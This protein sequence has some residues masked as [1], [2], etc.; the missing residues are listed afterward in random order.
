MIANE[1]EGMLNEIVMLC[2]KGQIKESS[3][4]IQQF[5]HSTLMGKELG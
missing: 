3:E 2:I 5:I 1:K 4:L